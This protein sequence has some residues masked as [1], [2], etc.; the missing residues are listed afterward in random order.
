MADICIYVQKGYALKTYKKESYNV[1]WFPGME[2][3]R[4]VLERA[5]YEVDYAGESTVH[6]YKIVLLSI[7]SSIDWY[8]F[9]AERVRWQKGNYVVIVGGAGN[10]NVRPVLPFVDISVFGRGEDLVVD[11]V[12]ETL[13]GNKFDHSAV[14]YSAEFSIKNRY[15][16]AQAT[17]LY[18]FEYRLANGNKFR[19][20][21]IGC[22]RKCLFCGYTWQREYRGD[23]VENYGVQPADERTIFDFDLDHPETWLEGCKSRYFIVGVDGMSERLRKMVN[24]PIT[25]EMLIKFV[26]GAVEISAEL[27]RLKLY[28][29]IGLPSESD[30][31]WQ[32]YFDTIVEADQTG[33]DYPGKVRLVIETVATQFKPIPASPAA[34]WPAYYFEYRDYHKKFKITQSPY[35]HKI[36][37]GKGVRLLFMQSV[38]SLPVHT[39]Q[40]L[41]NRGIEKDTDI[42]RGIATNKAFWNANAKKRRATLEKYLDI[43]RL[44]RAYT[45]EDLPTRYLKSYVPNRGFAKLSDRSR[46][47]NDGS[48]QVA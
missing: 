35:K 12:R 24:K 32:E 48:T 6:K 17:R 42:I 10:L 7:T 11:L 28:N 23:V 22:K 27:F 47:Y 14:C 30:S 13:A 40:M 45:W 39:L 46:F 9:I 19:E 36:Y 43:D 1:R 3:I 20:G 34:I 16:I 38:E 33:I 15:E 4:D 44:F 41:M 25:R 8:S 26:R 18:P 31:D 21:A 2:L 29:I 37:D 5:G